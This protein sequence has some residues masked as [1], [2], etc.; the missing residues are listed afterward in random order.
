MSSL[1]LDT[2]NQ[3]TFGI[4]NDDYEW[5]EYE[6]VKEQKA[7]KVLHALIQD[8]LDRHGLNLK[9]MESI[10]YLSGPGSYTGVR[11]A[12]GFAEVLMW[13]NANVFSC[14]HFDIPKILGIEKGI[15]ISNAF[16]KEAFVYTWDGESNSKRLVPEL[17]VEKV[18]NEGHRSFTCEPAAYPSSESTYDLIEKS[19][20]KIFP[21]LKKN[22]LKSDVFYYRALEDEF[23]KAKK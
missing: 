20:Q 21:Y 13:Q 3:I 4:L 15:F 6:V 1:F 23:D 5:V 17:E 12:Q 7:S 10:F 18:L 14:R 9:S 2:S 16:K 8:C 22:S 19:P 11:V